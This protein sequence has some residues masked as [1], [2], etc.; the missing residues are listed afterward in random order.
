MKPKNFVVSE[1]VMLLVALV[2]ITSM[3]VK[4]VSAADWSCEP[5]PCIPADATID[6]A[7][8]SL[9]VISA[10]SQTTVELHR[11]IA[12]WVETEV[13]WNNFGG[14]Y[15]AAVEGSFVPADTSW[16]TVDVTAVV[17]EWVYGINPNYGL[18]LEQ[19]QAD[20]T[21]Y[22]SSEYGEGEYR[23]QL[24]ICYTTS[25]GSACV[26][27]IRPCA[28]VADAFIWELHPDDNGGD[29][30]P[31]YTVFVNGKKKQTLIR[32]DFEL[33]DEPCCACRFTG[34]GVD[35]DGNWDHT[36]EDGEMVR[37][38]AGN[39]PEGV[40][41]AQ[42]GGQAGANTGQQPQPK[43]EW[44]H[45][46]QRGPSGSFTFHGG[47]A[48]APA[49]TEID[50]IRCSDPGGCKPSG[51]PPT[52]VKQLDFDGIGTFKSIGKGGKTPIFDTPS[53][54][55][56]AEGK[57]N[58]T[59]DGTFHWFEVNIDDLG[60]PGGFNKGAPDS[61]ECPDIGFGEKGDVELAN[62]DCPDFYRIT[63]YDGVNAADVV[64]LPDGSIDPTLLREQEVIY[65]F[66]GYI[67]GGN[68]QIHDPTGYDL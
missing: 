17:E 28:N 32:F 12:P 21:S 13:T 66:Y 68:L 20:V 16:V 8:L 30:H 64:W 43:G 4:P 5:V 54:N 7:A 53:A 24:E 35:T 56:T 18:L 1:R 51:H 38:G 6:S 9:W 60:E 19:G 59:F 42:F 67:D 48:S 47:T 40:D 49:G 26:R 36:L 23:P 2:L 31:L 33:C 27:L 58:K 57:G 10:G 15:D 25:G 61:G 11:I 50:E 37:N 3:A 62:C 45:H 22:P 65:E 29:S 55:A 52:P 39:L 46:Q 44:T 41:R 34:G 14:S 63:I